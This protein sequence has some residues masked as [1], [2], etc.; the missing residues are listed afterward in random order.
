LTNVPHQINKIPRLARGLS[1][2]VHLASRSDSLSDDRT[3]S[4]ALARA[5]VYTFRAQGRR[6]VAQ[7]L[8]E[9]HAK[10]P[11]QQGT[12]TAARD[13]H[14]LFSL[15]GFLERNADGQWLITDPS[16]SIHVFR[17]HVFLKSAGGTIVT[18]STALASGTCQH[19]NR[20]LYQKSTCSIF[21]SY[22]LLRVLMRKQREGIGIVV[23]QGCRCR[24]GHEWLPRDKGEKPRVCPKCKSPRWDMPKA[25]KGRRR[26][27]QSVTP[28]LQHA[29]ST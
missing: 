6:S 1:T 19:R 4:D 27:T 7:L 29:R 11:S 3:V 16:V 21:S 2:F 17:R 5:H 13:L 18:E 20:R 25:A 15:L 12:R 24:C 8:R 10:P 28:Q 26:L 9:E 23:L 14:R 22:F